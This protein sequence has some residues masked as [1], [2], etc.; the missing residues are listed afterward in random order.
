MRKS[1]RAFT[2]IELVIV[3]AIIGILAS[4]AVPKYLDISQQAKISAA[5]A[6]LGTLRAVLA[7]KYAESATSGNAASFPATVVDGDFAGGTAPTNAVSNKTGVAATASAPAGTAT[8]AAAGFWY[9]VSSGLAGAFSD[10]T[11]DTSSY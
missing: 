10:G 6:G 8:N 7:T 11:V 3:I 2:L 4:L 9:I 5:K 1:L